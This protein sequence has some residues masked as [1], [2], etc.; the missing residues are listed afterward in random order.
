MWLL[1]EGSLVE[2]KELA[3][4]FRSIRFVNDIRRQI[5]DIA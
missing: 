5:Y 3:L 4:D 2:A 1:L